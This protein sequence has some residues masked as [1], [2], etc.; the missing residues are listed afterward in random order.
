MVADS[1]VGGAG[2]AARARERRLLQIVFGMV[3]LFPLGLGAAVA[4]TGLKGFWLLFGLDGEAPAVP[5]LDSGVR[6]LGANFFGMGLVAAWVLPKIEE[7]TA[8]F[9]IFVAAA[10]FGATA[11][12]ISHFAVG[13][14]NL[15]T[16]ALIG[17][18]ASV[19]LLGFWQARVARLYREASP[20]TGQGP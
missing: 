20:T 11:R 14:P 19:L 9:R 8:A 2:G 18:E 5:T 13:A 10:L 6:F 3:A 16:Q 15:F 4:L 7:R 12:V 1:S 17:V